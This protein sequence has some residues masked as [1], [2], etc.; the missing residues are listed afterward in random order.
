MRRLT[1]ATDRSRGAASKLPYGIGSSEKCFEDSGE[2]VSRR[3]AV[4]HKSAHRAHGDRTER[5]SVQRDESSTMTA[6]IKMAKPA[7]SIDDQLPE[8]MIPSPFHPWP[9][10]GF[11][12]LAEPIPEP[13]VNLVAWAPGPC[14]ATDFHGPGATVL[15]SALRSGVIVGGIA[16]CV[17]LLLNVI[18]SV[19]CPRSYFDPRRGDVE[20][21]SIENGA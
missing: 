6:N 7:Q 8:H 20:M 12:T 4:C 16:G 5:T 15:G 13:I 14:I 18:G 17:S 19:A 21:K 10:A 11:R 3:C 2:K 1:V 9:E